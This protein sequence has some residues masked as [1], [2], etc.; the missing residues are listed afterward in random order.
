MNKPKIIS[1]TLSE[2]D[3]DCPHCNTTLAIILP[4]GKDDI[5]FPELSE[6]EKDLLE[7]I[8]KGDITTDGDHFPFIDL[9]NNKIHSRQCDGYIRGG[10]CPHCGEL[11]YALELVVA[12]APVPYF[13][14]VETDEVLLP[15]T[16]KNYEATYSH[17]IDDVELPQK[18]YYTRHN[19]VTFVNSGGNNVKVAVDRHF[20]GLMAI[21]NIKGRLDITLPRSLDV[22]DV[23]WREA[24]ILVNQ[25]IDSFIENIEGKI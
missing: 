7:R 15:L 6:K 25:I 18:W 8:G 20:V 9:N 17:D 13:T 19:N 2:F 21:D 12:S 1:E 10:Q 14:Y 4:Y 11:Y 24:S 3:L 5:I 22:A 23:C 16:G